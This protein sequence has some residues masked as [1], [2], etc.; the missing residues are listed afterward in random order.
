MNGDKTDLDQDNALNRYTDES[1]N[2]RPIETP[3]PPMPEDEEGFAPD[4]L[5]PVE[6]FDEEANFVE[7]GETIDLQE[8]APTLRQLTVAIGWDQKAIEEQKLDADISC[9]L[10]NKQDLTRMD[11]DFVFYNNASGCDDAVRH[12]E[13]NRTG[14]GDGDD[15]TMELSL[16]NIP[17][18]VLKI[19]FTLS[20]YDPEFESY[21]LGM[22]RNVYLRMLNKEDE[23]EIFRYPVKQE[24]M[25]KQTCLIIASMTRAG[26]G[27]AVEIMDEAVEGG[28]AAIAQKYGLLIAQ[29]AG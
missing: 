9:F 28:L 21:H 3:P 15:E 23:F 8:K 22:A 7:C 10:L 16:E 24:A 5:P 18:E 27:W 19:V 25:E 29:S 4:D 20:V 13:D 11:S 12:L 26:A 14:A 6:E 17:F 1:D 2:I